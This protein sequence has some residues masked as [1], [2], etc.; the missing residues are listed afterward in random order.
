MDENSGSQVGNH[1]YT[2]RDLLQGENDVATQDQ[3][4]ENQQPKNTELAEVWSS[5]R[6]WKAVGTGYAVNMN[7][8]ARGHAELPLTCHSWPFAGTGD[9]LQSKHR[10]YGPV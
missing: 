10:R 8:I 3:D 7:L 5:W 6:T 2:K 9:K 1:D 4:T